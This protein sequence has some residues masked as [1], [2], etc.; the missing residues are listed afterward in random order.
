MPERGPAQLL[1]LSFHFLRK[2]GWRIG[3][4]AALAGLLGVMPREDGVYHEAK[5]GIAQSLRQAAWSRAVNGTNT[6]QS[7]PWDDGS[8]VAYSKVPRLG[9]SA[10]MQDG[11]RSDG[12]ER[13]QRH[14]IASEDRRDP[15]LGDVALGDEA[16]RGV[17]EADQVR[18]ALG[19][20]GESLPFTG[21][22]DPHLLAP[23]PALSFGEALRLFIETGKLDAFATQATSGELKL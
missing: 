1:L 18:R 20:V 5:S 17:T 4:A 22:T 8:P 21:A 14:G 16:A 11:R 7:W 23:R 3:L 2:S 19:A 13:G 9:L 10:A 12:G 15:H 6:H